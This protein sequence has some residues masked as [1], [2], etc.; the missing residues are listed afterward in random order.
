MNWYKKYKISSNET[1]V[2][3]E[4]ITRIATYCIDY[5][6]KKE[7]RM[8][9]S[10]PESKYSFYNMRLMIDNEQQLSDL[11]YKYDEEVYE[12]IQLRIEQILEERENRIFKRRKSKFSD[13][14]IENVRN[15]IRGKT[16]EQAKHTVS[17]MTPAG[18]FTDKKY[19]P[20]DEMAETIFQ[21]LYN[22][23]FF[24]T[25]IDIDLL[26][27]VSPFSGS[28]GKPVMK[29]LG[30]IRNHGSFSSEREDKEGNN[31]YIETQL[32]L[33]L[34]GNV[35][36]PPKTIKVY[37]GTSNPNSKIRPGDYVTPDRDYARHYVR[38]N[39]GVIIGDVV[40]VQDLIISKIPYD[41][42]AVELVYY[43]ISFQQEIETKGQDSFVKKPPMT[44]RELWE[45]TN[46]LR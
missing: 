46:G 1:S 33:H 36:T 17:E 28:D 5:V 29:R 12:K 35:K 41:F 27:S 43:P 34:F 38:G 2:S 10:D 7:W 18:K 15:M 30:E 45:E 20:D 40:P 21:K 19:V 11:M 44:L 31:R 8:F 13:D 25:F 26:R 24:G 23:H 9:K 42:G 3:D 22:V 16:W 4:E 32:F 39:A 14:P 37:R 6:W